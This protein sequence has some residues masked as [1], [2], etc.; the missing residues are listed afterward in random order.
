MYTSQ[1]AIHTFVIIPRFG[2][3]VIPVS[4]EAWSKFPCLVF[5]I[6]VGEVTVEE[7]LPPAVPHETDGGGREGGREG[8]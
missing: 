1:L 8:G 2:E 5:F 3:F 6:E 4:L 7:R